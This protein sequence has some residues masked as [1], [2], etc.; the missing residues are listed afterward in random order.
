MEGGECF[1]VERALML[2]QDYRL[3]KNYNIKLHAEKILKWKHPPNGVLKINVDG[4]LFSDI[5]KSGVGAILLDEAGYVILAMSKIENEMD[6]AEDIKSLAALRG[7]QMICHMG[8]G[9]II[10]ESDSLKVVEAF[11]TYQ[12]RAL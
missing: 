4:A 3:V 8:I 2:A 9:A 12:D 11:Q 10:L 1:A 6:E 7:L 5:K